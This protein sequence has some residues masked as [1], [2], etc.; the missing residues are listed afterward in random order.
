MEQQDKHDTSGLEIAI[1]GMAG[2]FPGAPDIGAFWNNIRDGVE[3]AVTYTDAQLR[4]RG[5][6][7]A[8]LD[9]PAY[10]KAGVPFDGADQFDAGFF[11]YTPRDAAQLDPQHRIFLECASRRSRLCKSGRAI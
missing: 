10:V 8:L 7:Q 11:G 9:D 6:P 3:S 2:R 5:V 1:V 4:E